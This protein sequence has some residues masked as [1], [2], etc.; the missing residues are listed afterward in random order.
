MTLT[1]LLG[2]TELG[3]LLKFPRLVSHYWQHHYN[4]S[5][6]DFI[7]FLVMHYI[8]EDDGTSADNQE[9]EQLPFHNFN[10]QHSFAQTLPPLVR[11]GYTNL[12]L[13]L[14]P[15]TF[16]V[17]PQEGFPSGHVSPVLQPPRV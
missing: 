5:S 1:H 13:S 8:Y 17:K 9:D 2:N 12:S 14:Q 6:V 16:G 3:E 7:D 4:D 15:N 11:L 10:H